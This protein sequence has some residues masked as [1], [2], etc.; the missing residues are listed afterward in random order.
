MVPWGSPVTIWCRGTL[1]AQEFHLDKEGTSVP[2]DRQK[3][4]EP[5]DKA[6]FS[7]Y[8][9]GQ[10]HTGSYRCYY[11]TPTGWSE[12]SDCLKL[13]VTGEGHSGPRAL[14]LGGG[15]LSGPVSLPA[16]PWGV[17]GEPQGTSCLLLS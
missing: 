11:K 12:P 9:M 2:W 1:E 14:L 8:Y 15:L 6:K 5:G 13:V 4:L 7:I 17:R 16:Q 3:P 10:D